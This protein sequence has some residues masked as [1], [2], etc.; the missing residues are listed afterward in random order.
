MQRAAR[1]WFARSSNQI[2]LSTATRGLI[3]TATPLFVLS[4][5]GDGELAHF[6]VIGAIGISMVDVGGPY[7]RRLAAMAIGAVL[8]PCLMM[9]GLAVG[10]NWWLAGLVM[11]GLAIGSSLV[12]AFGPGGVSFGINMSVAF[13]IGLGGA[14]F[15]GGNIEIWAGGYFCG[16]LWTVAV[17]LAFWQAR[18]YRRLEQEV[19][20][21]W[22]AVADLVAAV[23]PEAGGEPGTAATRRRREQLIVTRHRAAREAI[24]RAHDVLGEVRA[25]ISGPGTTMAQLVVLVASASRVGVAALTLGETVGAGGC[26]AG[27]TA[28]LQ[29]AVDQL[30]RVTRSIAQVLLSGRGDIDIEPL[31]RALA[32]LRDGPDGTTGPAMLAMARAVRNLANAE[33]ALR[34]LG[35]R[36]PRALRMVRLPLGSGSAGELVDPVRKHVTLSSPIFRHALRVAAVAAP[37]TAAIVKFDVPHG[38]WLPMTAIIVLQP[39][40]G[41]TLERAVQRSAGTVVGAVIAGV[42]RVMLHKTIAFEFSIAILLFATFFLIR[43]HYGQAIAFLTPLIILLIGVSGPDPWAD[44]RDRILY[45][46]LGAIVAIVAGFILWPQWEHER[47]P[48]RLVAA[49]RAG[50]RYVGAVLDALGAPSPSVDL[51]PL[52]RTAEVEVTNL[53]AAFQRVTTEPSRQRGRVGKLF[54]LT[55]YIHRLCRH[56]I[57]LE[58]HLGAAALPVELL[59]P[60]QRLVEAGLDDIADALAHGRSSGPRPAFDEPLARLR[61]SLAHSG[62]NAGGVNLLLGQIISDITALNTAAA[63]LAAER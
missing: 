60:L 40:Y 3:A 44:V 12:R 36:R 30:E 57:A 25:E 23:K 47:L 54:M 63:A 17:T 31:R 14:P 34:F 42:L 37:C 46:L 5:L 6:A 50:R 61:D 4:W 62:A 24:E 21:A 43:R 20:G 32:P 8:G 59:A 22:Q 39:D 7:R 15:G 53:E 19:A 56:A 58:T 27:A 26:G 13:L 49:L 52:R 38:I 55:V 48:D 11:V 10:N 18:P 51:G 28:S 45:T 29:A 1:D 33:E 41:G 2:A 35:S 16:A 9:I